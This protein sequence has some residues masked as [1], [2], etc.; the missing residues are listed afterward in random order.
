[1]EDFREVAGPEWEGTLNSYKASIETNMKWRAENEQKIAS[2]LGA[3][4][5]EVDMKMFKIDYPTLR[6]TVPPQGD[7]LISKQKMAEK[8]LRREIISTF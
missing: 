7:L 1:M 5:Y 6:H 8:P 2:W 3:S 4:N